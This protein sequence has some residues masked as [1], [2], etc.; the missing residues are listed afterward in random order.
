VDVEVDLFRRLEDRDVD[1]DH[2]EWS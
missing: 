1:G 2:F